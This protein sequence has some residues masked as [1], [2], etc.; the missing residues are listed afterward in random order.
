MFK[1]LVHTYGKEIWVFDQTENRWLI[2]LNSDGVLKFNPKF[3]DK[4]FNYFSLNQKDYKV[5]IK[6]W[7][8]K[9]FNFPVR[10][11][12][13]CSSNLDYLTETMLNKKNDKKEWKLNDRFDFSYELV[14]K[15]L[16]LKSKFEKVELNAFYSAKLSPQPQVLDAFGF[17][18]SNPLPFNPSE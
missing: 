3:F 9:I 12:E 17:T 18:H 16:E 15:F 1:C 10:Q 14:K 6:D 7:L 13:R 5:I 2:I 8:E 11:V 4:I